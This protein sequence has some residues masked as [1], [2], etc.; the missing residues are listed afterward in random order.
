M[1]ALLIFFCIFF[2]SSCGRFERLEMKGTDRYVVT[3]I[4]AKDYT[5]DPRESPYLLRNSHVWLSEVYHVKWNDYVIIATRYPKKSS[6]HEYYIIHGR[7]STLNGTPTDTLIGPL[8][9]FQRDSII[10]ARRLDTST[11]KEIDFN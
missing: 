1:R 9:L 2:I 10:A 5:D 11:M 7:D 4:Y 8:T 6:F 3:N